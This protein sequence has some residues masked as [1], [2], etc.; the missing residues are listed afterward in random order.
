MSDS[1]G[2]PGVTEALWEHC[3]EVFPLDVVLLLCAPGPNEEGLERFGGDPRQGTERDVA[4]GVDKHVAVAGGVDLGDQPLGGHEV[5]VLLANLLQTL[6]PVVHC[7]TGVVVAHRVEPGGLAHQ[8]LLFGLVSRLGDTGGIRNRLVLVFWLCLVM[9]ISRLSR[10]HVQQFERD[11]L[12]DIF[13][14]RFAGLEGQEGDAQGNQG[15]EGVPVD[16]LGHLWN[17]VGGFFGVFWHL[18]PKEN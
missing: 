18:V 15:A 8:C 7:G 5:A 13:H 14:G 2:L 9:S 10:D 16:D 4:L 11:L 12:P 6:V 17:G 1:D 3:P